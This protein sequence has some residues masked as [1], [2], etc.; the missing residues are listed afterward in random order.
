[1]NIGV[2]LQR[3]NTE[4]LIWIVYLFI[5][6]AAL[7]SD[8]YERNYLKTNNP[9]SKK[10]FKLINITVLT[11]ALFIYLYFI[12]LNY[13]DIKHLK[14]E[15][16]RKEVIT[17]HVALIAALLFFI[18]GILTWIAEINRNTPDNDFGII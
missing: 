8:Q 17:S 12:I 14:K 15:T 5:A 10:K 11:I 7:I 6:L 16:T 3:L 13:D 4:D 18:G 1:M 2:K 9:N